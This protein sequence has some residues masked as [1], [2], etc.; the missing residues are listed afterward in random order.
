MKDCKEKETRDS[1]TGLYRL[2]YGRELVGACLSR[3]DPYTS[4]G[5]LAVN[6]D[7]FK[8]INERYGRPA[9]DRVLIGLAGF[10]LDCV[11][12]NGVV[13]RAEGDEFLIFIKSIP[14]QEMVRRMVLFMEGIRSLKFAGVSEP[15]T[16]SI[17]VC[18]LP[19]NIPGYS[20]E[21]MEENARWA[22]RQ[23][24]RKGKNQF[25]FCDFLRQGE[26]LE[27]QNRKERKREIESRY[28]QGS[29]VSAAFEI[30]EKAGSF[31][32]AMELLL[33]VVGLRYRLDRITVIRT[34]IR[35]KT[36]ERMY[37]WLGSGVSEALTAPEGFSK[38]DFL[39]LF[40][41]YDSHGTIV[42][43]EDG[44]EAYSR[45]AVRLLM[46]GDAKTILYAA[47]Y[48]DGQ[49]TGAISFVSCKEKREWTKEERSQLGELTKIVSA[50]LA[51]NLAVN[52]SH[53]RL[54]VQPGF[55]PVTGLISFTRFKEE[56]ERLILGG[57]G[58][59]YGMAYID[60]ED[61]KHFNRKFGYSAGD[62][63][64]KNY[65]GFMTGRLSGKLEVHFSRVVADQFV[66]FLPCP[67]PEET[68]KWLEEAHERFAA[69]QYGRMRG[70]R[71]RI[72][73]GLYPISPNCVSA[74]AAIDAANFAR[75]E[76]PKAGPSV[77]L[78]D[79]QLDQKQELEREVQSSLEEGKE[80]ERFQVYLQPKFSV[81]DNRVTGA[82][83]LVRWKRKD[84]TMAAPNLFLP[85]LE[86]TGRIVDLDFY[87]FEKV[88]E[89]LQKNQRLHRRQVPVSIN[90][91]ALH[92]LE[93][94]AASHYLSI[95]N[96][97]GVD[98]SLVEIELT[99]TAAVS[100]Y[101]SARKLFGALRNAGIHTSMDDFGA[102]YSVL[103]MITDIP[104][105]T[106]K[107]DGLL[108]KNCEQG[109]RGIYFLKSLIGLVKGLGYHVICEG[110]EYTE[111]V[112]ILKEIGCD[113]AQGFWFSPPVPLAQYEEQMYGAGA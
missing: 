99:E 26:K 107:I 28:F 52:A 49:Y 112:R 72:R 94:D 2:E 70:L 67:K 109:E 10:L 25:V 56:T 58:A 80:T 18:F 108:I 104:V 63:L 57:Y 42:L 91:S 86:K 50:H 82:E 32:E 24:K 9:G 77:K 93:E 71:L 17:G 65:C 36:A 19:E 5:M 33:E 95:L 66:L 81:T 89:F 39:T 74:S 38:E 8:R 84:G 16:C 59:S 1:L 68:A 62:E 97:Y 11:R 111:Q 13:I 83:A 34:D 7:D 105:D 100:D 6:V 106:V 37:Q 78:Y 102:G 75:K 45:P 103:N 22:L 23:A 3:R 101:D 47:M 41:G 76:L 46:Q 4:C 20:C 69:E 48:T 60:F 21:Y 79:A 14:H 43:H 98:P 64:L 92:A 96:R 53:L 110:V 12:E 54:T 73:A 27:T 85:A 31:Q 90:A 88:A 51:R 113:E 29:V 40:H 55:D 15:V 87:V 35:E 61:F 44:M 30:F